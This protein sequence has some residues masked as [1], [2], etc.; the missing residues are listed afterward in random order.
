MNI[1]FKANYIN[2]GTVKKID[3]S[4]NYLAHDASFVSLNPKNKK[5]VLALESING[6]WDC[7]FL[8]SICNNLYRYSK[9][10][11]LYALTTQEKNFEDLNPKQILGIAVGEHNKDQGFYLDFLQTNPKHIKGSSPYPDYKNIG[12]AIL[13]CIK[14]FYGIKYIKADSVPT[15]FNFYIKNEFNRTSDFLDDFEIIWHNTTNL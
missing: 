10:T 13:N 8:R 12:T 15:A 4:F 7:S 11:R 3:R 5:D 9:R 6:D 2:T 1:N 14:Q